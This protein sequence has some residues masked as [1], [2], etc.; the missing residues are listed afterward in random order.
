MTEADGDQRRRRRRARLRGRPRDAGDAAARAGGRR[1]PV[2]SRLAAY[3]E[4]LSEGRYGLEFEPGDVQTL[5]AQLAAADR[6][7]RSCAR[8]RRD[9]A[10]PLRATLR[11]SRVADELQEIYDAARRAPARRPRRAR[12]SGASSPPGR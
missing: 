2:T 11:W 8:A 9:A 5:A 10:E 12:R 7:S 1:V 3:E 4:L 6:Q